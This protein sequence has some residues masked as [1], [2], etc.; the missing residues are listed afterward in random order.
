MNGIHDMGGMDGFGKVEVE[1][2]EPPFHERWEGRVLA[3]NRS[4]GFAGAWHIDDTRYA[5]ETLPPQVYLAASYY[6]RW[7]LAM[8]KNLIRRGL[9]TPE[10][11]AAGHALQ[12]AKPLPRKLTPE[13]VAAGLT[14]SS[15]F[16]QQQGPARFKP[17]DR[18]RTVNINPQTHTRLPR[19]ARDKLGVVELIH[20]CHAYPDSVATDRGDDPQWL[21]TVV[22]DGR[23]IWGP[24]ADPTLTVSIDAFEPYL[25]PA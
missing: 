12:P 10:E 22:F 9:V 3:M 21:Y 14:R 18:V 13:V 25:E 16:R 2:N 6:W 23:E 11:L 5:Q 7:E 24:D 19:Y 20:G 1:A 4:M 15:F 8:E 17:G